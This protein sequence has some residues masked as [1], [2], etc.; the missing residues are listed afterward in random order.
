[1]DK[2]SDKNDPQHGRYTK[3]SGEGQPYLDHSTPVLSSPSLCFSTL[4]DKINILSI[5]IT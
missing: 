2:L 1:M 4:L 5:M 3:L